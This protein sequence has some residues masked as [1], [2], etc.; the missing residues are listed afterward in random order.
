MPQHK[1]SL[2]LLK[3]MDD[4]GLKNECLSEILTSAEHKNLLC[5]VSIKAT[6]NQYLE[7][8]IF[9]I[10]HPSPKNP[11][12]SSMALKINVHIM[13]FMVTILC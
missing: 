5:K 10:M 8:A 4:G 9:V 1:G 7:V 6:F 2:V 3:A 13:G 11:L 12:P